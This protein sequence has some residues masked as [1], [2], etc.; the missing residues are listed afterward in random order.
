[1]REECVEGFVVKR[2]GQTDRVRGWENNGNAADRET[3]WVGVDWVNLAQDKGKVKI[4]AA[5]SG[6]HDTDACRHIVSLPL[7]EFTPS[8]EALHTKQA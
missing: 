3:E 7:T 2:E 6:L 5:L 8:P 4:K 1:M